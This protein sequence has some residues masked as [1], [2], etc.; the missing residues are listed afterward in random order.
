MSYP[1]RHGLDVTDHELAALAAY[2]RE[3]SVLA[4]ARSMGRSPST[5]R[6]QLAIVRSKLGVSRTAQAAL[7]LAERLRT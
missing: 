4:A 3:G 1:S 5:I 2:L 6:E 7:I